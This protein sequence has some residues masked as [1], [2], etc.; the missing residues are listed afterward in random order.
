VPAGVDDISYSLA[1]PACAS[2]RIATRPTDA[3]LG[4]LRS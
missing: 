4:F 2:W 1:L 3:G